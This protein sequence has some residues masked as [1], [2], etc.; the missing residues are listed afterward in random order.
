[1]ELRFTSADHESKQPAYRLRWYNTSDEV[2]YTSL[3]AH[4]HAQAIAG[5]SPTV[6][7]ITP[8]PKPT[9]PHTSDYRITVEAETP[10]GNSGESAPSAPF[11][12]SPPAVPADVVVIDPLI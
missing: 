3:S 8:V 6:Y 11:S 2:V 4:S 9:G 10:I 1:M 12:L 7:R 5:T